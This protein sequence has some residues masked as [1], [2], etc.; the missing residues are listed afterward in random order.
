MTDCKENIRAE[1]VH[2]FTSSTVSIQPNTPTA[3]S[4]PTV[5]YSRK[6]KRD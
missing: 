5:A 3:L 6:K 2:P 4:K 1:N